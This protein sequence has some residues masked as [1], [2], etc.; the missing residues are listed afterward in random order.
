[1][2]PDS[3]CVKPWLKLN[4]HLFG[5]NHFNPQFKLTLNRFENVCFHVDIS[6]LYLTTVLGNLLG[7]R[8][9]SKKQNTSYQKCIGRLVHTIQTY[10]QFKANQF[11]PIVN[12]STYP[13]SDVYSCRYVHVNYVC[14]SCTLFHVQALSR[15]LLTPACWDKTLFWTVVRCDALLILL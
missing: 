11:K 6:Y 13:L 8:Y 12:M 10:V 4:M 9:C 2:F 3:F 5:V 7:L 1:M 14:Y 15:P